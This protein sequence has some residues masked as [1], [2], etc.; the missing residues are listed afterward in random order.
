[1]S[2]AIVQPP[3]PLPECVS[4]DNADQARH[5]LARKRKSFLRRF[6]SLPA[7]RRRHLSNNTNVS[8]NETET[9]DI[10]PIALS[11]VNPISDDNSQ[12]M[13]TWAV[14]YENQRGHVFPCI[15]FPST[16]NTRL[17]VFS[18]P[19]YSHRSLLPMDPA[20]FT[21][22]SALLKRSKQPFISLNDYQLP[23]GTWRWVSKSWMIDMRS[24]NGEIQ[25]DG[26]EYNWF[27][28][29]HH[30]R[31][32]VGSLSA[33]GLVRRRRWIRLMLR[34]AKQRNQEDE[35]CADGQKTSDTV[36]NRH[37]TGDLLDVDVVWQGQDTEE[38]WHRCHTLMKRLDR[39]GHKLD[40]WLAWLESLSESVDKKGFA[41][42]ISM[43]ANTSKNEQ[44]MSVL[45]RHVCPELESL[46]SD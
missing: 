11:G 3:P 44:I 43:T 6:L 13:F 19:Y 1:M 31:G 16:H 32:E 22:P 20:P 45:N 37:E 8:T 46:S 33:G 12:D 39:D 29:R 18:T 34:P 36:A 2:S 21:L 7:L 10:Q 40:I 28:R 35:E 17:T 24:D 42:R 41:N 25:H 15:E 38:N 9:T 5:R 23:D 27:F 4:P 14:L 26:F 30:W